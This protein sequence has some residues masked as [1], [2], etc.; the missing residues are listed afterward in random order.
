MRFILFLNIS[1]C[2]MQEV[3]PRLLHLDVRSC[4]IASPAYGEDNGKVAELPDH[5][6]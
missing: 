2:R 5:A 6:R 1:T 4:K 3:P